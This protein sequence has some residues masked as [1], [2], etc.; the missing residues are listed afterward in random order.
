MMKAFTEMTAGIF[1]SFSTPVLSRVIDS[2]L[3]KDITEEYVLVALGVICLGT[4]LA[5][6]GMY[7]E[8]RSGSPII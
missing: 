4:F 7:R 2:S 8:I 5:F 1:L 6:H 3:G